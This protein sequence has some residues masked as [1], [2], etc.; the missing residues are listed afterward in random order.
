MSALNL[1]GL[2]PR[3]LWDV[4]SLADRVTHLPISSCAPSAEE[5]SD[6]LIKI[7]SGRSNEPL[8]SV[9]RSFRDELVDSMGRPVSDLDPVLVPAVVENL[10]KAP[11]LSVASPSHRTDRTEG[12]LWPGHLRRETV[13]GWQ[14]P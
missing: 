11:R 10:I 1:D 14:S 8:K 9:Q 5:A 3:S 7:R 2:S 13:S 12:S 6:R 4:W